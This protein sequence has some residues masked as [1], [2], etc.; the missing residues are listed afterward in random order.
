ML[1]MRSVAGRRQ[2]DAVGT[3][4]LEHLMASFETLLDIQFA[5]RGPLLRTTALQALPTEFREGVIDSSN[6]MARRFAGAIIDGISEG[7]I[8]AV[9]PLIASQMLMPTINSAYELRGWAAAM[10]PEDAIRTYAATIATGL[11]DRS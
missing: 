9:D 6:R 4:H 5:E 8:R 2:A 7:S 10:A 1:C 3:T 11:F